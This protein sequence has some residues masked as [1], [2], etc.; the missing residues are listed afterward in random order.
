MNNVTG[1]MCSEMSASKLM[2]TSVRQID[3]DTGMAL[4]QHKRHT[5]I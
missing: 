3:A 5:F 4:A 2:T 1:K